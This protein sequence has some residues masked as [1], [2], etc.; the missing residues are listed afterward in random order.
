[1]TKLVVPSTGSTAQT[2]SLS[3]PGL[4]SRFLAENVVAGEALAEPGADQ[5]L[6]IAVDLG[7]RV[8]ERGGI[9]GASLIFHRQHLAERVLDFGAGEAGELGG[10]RFQVGEQARIERAC[11]DGCHGGS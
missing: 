11:L 7:N 9:G 1:M 8:P 4:S 6:D 2:K 5:Q 3:R 10:G